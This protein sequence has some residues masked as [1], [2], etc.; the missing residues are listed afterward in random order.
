MAT[1]LLQ[2]HTIK[3]L[4][5]AL[6]DGRLSY[7]EALCAS[8]LAY[9]KEDRDFSFALTNLMRKY[10]LI[11]AEVTISQPQEV[12]DVL[13]PHNREEAERRAEWLLK[14]IATKKIDGAESAVQMLS[15]WNKV[16]TDERTKRIVI[17]FV[18]VAIPGPTLGYIK[19]R[20]KM[21]IIT[22]HNLFT[23]S[24]VELVRNASKASHDVLA[25][26]FTQ[27]GDDMSD[28][29]P[30]VGDW[31]FGERELSFYATDAKT[32]SHIN[33]E[34]SEFNILHTHVADEKGISLVAVSPVV[35]SDY[36]RAQWHLE[37]L[38]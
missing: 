5:G 34:L 19:K 16:Q 38:E 12:C 29:E 33:E 30:D 10:A 20:K 28:L 15:F 22:R 37:V 26:A 31:F 13:K 1:Q 9:A 35:N 24:N 27:A 4:A 32:L 21:P 8:L 11:E 6:T 25:Q 18:G 7:A 36:Q 14:K 2:P 17:G 23:S 3:M